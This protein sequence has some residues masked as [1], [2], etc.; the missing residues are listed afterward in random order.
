MIADLQRLQDEVTG[1]AEKTFPSQSI[2]SKA[3]HLIDEAQEIWETP[4]DLVEHADALLLLLQ[5]TKMAGY[6]AEDLMVAS[7]AKL[8]INKRRQWQAADK[9]G[10]HKHANG[11][12][13]A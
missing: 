2:E 9:R 12:E 3:A 13:A 6:T 4:R 1:W 5:L 10:V 8:D 11:T 7:F